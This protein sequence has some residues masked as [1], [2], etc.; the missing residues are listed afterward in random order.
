MACKCGSNFI[1]NKK[2]NLC[3]NC[4]YERLHEGKS[5]LEV[6]IEK[7]ENKEC[8][9]K[10]YKH[11]KAKGDITIQLKKDKQL[12]RFKTDEKTYFEVFSTK[13]HECQEC[14]YPLPDEFYD[15]KGNINYIVQYSHILGKA[16]FS[17]F[18]NKLKNFNRLCGI[19]HDQW[20]FG[21][22]ESMQIYEDNQII[23]QELFD[24]FNQEKREKEK[25]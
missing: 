21:D 2:Y 20:E 11:K 17:Q 1:V 9:F 23:I 18:R 6:I 25:S 4:N 15:E 10:R 14:H 5:R 19:H 3:S 16:A 13:P 12:K 7:N 8:V 22:K 24:E